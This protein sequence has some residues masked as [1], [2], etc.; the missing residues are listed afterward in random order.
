MADVNTPEDTTPKKKI[1][2]VTIG[3]IAGAAVVLL[4]GGFYLYKVMARGKVDALVHQLTSPDIAQRKD[5]EDEL[6]KRSARSRLVAEV[7]YENLAVYAGDKQ[8]MEELFK[9]LLMKIGDDN[10]VDV[11]S[12]GLADPQTDRYTRKASI[13]ILSQIRKESAARVLAGLLDHEDEAE[14]AMNGLITIGSVALPPLQEAMKHKDPAVRKR[15]VLA[16]GR[17]ADEAAQPSLAEALKDED[18]EV[19]MA[20]IT[21]LPDVGGDGLLDLLLEALEDENEEVRQQAIIHLETHADASAVEP[22]IG[23]LDDSSARVRAMAAKILGN[24]GD[25]RAMDPLLESLD[26]KDEEV[27]VKIVQ[28]LATLDDEKA[29]EPLIGLLDHQASTVR[30]SAITALGDLGDISA[31]DP[32]LNSQEATTEAAVDAY[33]KLPDTRATETLIQIMVKEISLKEKAA[34]ALIAID[35]PRTLELAMPALKESTYILKIKRD[36]ARKLMAG[37][38]EQTITVEEPLDE[39]LQSEEEEEEEEEEETSP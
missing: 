34:G 29:V 27:L 13:Q 33:G 24:L 11:V 10:T 4:L 25:K 28:A 39:Q 35:D 7:L 16:M 21:Y 30:L 19:R 36:L 3:I 37:L 23:A 32:I 38:T 5:A 1:T 20:A 17:I 31:L 12:E 9:G 18:A 6:A 26:E 2:P 8:D 14:D 15:A 22:I